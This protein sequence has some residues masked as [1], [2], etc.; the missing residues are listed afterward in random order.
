[1]DLVSSSKIEA[2]IVLSFYKHELRITSGLHP[3]FQELDFFFGLDDEKDFIT[4]LT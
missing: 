2:G 4:F 3:F 1:M